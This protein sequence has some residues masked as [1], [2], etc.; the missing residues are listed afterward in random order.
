MLGP[1]RAPDVMLPRSLLQSG[2]A[3]SPGA[4][5]HSGVP[6]Q[7]PSSSS[8]SWRPFGTI[9]DALSSFRG[10]GGSRTV[11]RG[12]SGGGVSEC[13]APPHDPHRVLRDDEFVEDALRDA[14]LKTDEEF[15]SDCCASMVGSTAVVALLGKKRIWVANC[16]ACCD[17]PC[18]VLLAH[19][20]I[21]L[22]P[23]G[24]LLLRNSLSLPVAPF[25]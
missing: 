1:A 21:N 10:G 22:P 14:F 13:S 16:G 8:S 25:P 7:H 9:Q 3:V 23:R 18:S 5:H 6:K 20:P 17:D 24:G 19:P 11:G 2:A 15:A 4:W 12:S